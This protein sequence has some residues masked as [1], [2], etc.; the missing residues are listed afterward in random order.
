MNSPTTMKSLLSPTVLIC[1]LLSSSSNLG[2]A[3]AEPI[4]FSSG[5]T[6]LSC[7]GVGAT[8][9]P[10]VPV[11]LT[12]VDTTDGDVTLLLEPLG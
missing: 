7:D 5:A 2:V 9:S 1:T 10:G 3:S 6:K 4:S 12:D 11:L 8:D